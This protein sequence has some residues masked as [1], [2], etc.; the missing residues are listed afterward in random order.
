MRAVSSLALGVALAAGAAEA[1]TVISREISTQPVE[2]V[3]TQGPYGTTIT[4]RPLAPNELADTYAPGTFVQQ[5]LNL[6]P[7]Y[8]PSFRPPASI[9]Q[10]VTRPVAPPVVAQEP[11][12]VERVT[13][14]TVIREPV[15]GQPRSV[16]RTV[17]QRPL[18]T[19]AT[20]IARGKDVP[21]LAKGEVLPLRRAAGTT[22][23]A[24]TPAEKRI[25]YRTIVRERVVS[26]P[27]RRDIVTTTV[28]PALPPPVYVERR[29][30]VPTTAYVE[31]RYE[32]PWWERRWEQPVY[33]SATY[34]NGYSNGYVNNWRAPVV[35]ADDEA[36]VST[37]VVARG[38]AYAIGTLLPAS[39]PLYGVPESLLFRV[40]TLRP[41]RYAYLGEQVYLVDPLSNVI[42]AVVTE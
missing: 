41:Y 8:E 13:T 27:V 15:R 12:E 1:Q 26:Q 11:V 33:N 32:Q 30:D 29:S 38:P 22:R 14:R 20:P 23:V 3:V 4:R 34:Q 19:A 6:A 24:L 39:V 37:P 21:I 42:V 25:V 18:R 2:T 9:P 35:A 36:V 40:P 31:R 17:V 5:P 28:A 10:V 7:S 16:E